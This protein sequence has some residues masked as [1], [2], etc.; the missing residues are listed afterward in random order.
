MKIFGVGGVG[1]GEGWGG[2]AGRNSARRKTLD[3]VCNKT[4]KIINIF[5]VET[6]KNTTTTVSKQYHYI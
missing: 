6:P 4:I 1:G 5:Y 3:M 2:G